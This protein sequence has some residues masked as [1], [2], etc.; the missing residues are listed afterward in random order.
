MSRI[1]LVFSPWDVSDIWV[2]T[3]RELNNT[4]FYLFGVPNFALLVP[5]CMSNMY[6]ENILIIINPQ[7]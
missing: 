2:I 5:F 3:N 6:M 7:I 4:I 1:I